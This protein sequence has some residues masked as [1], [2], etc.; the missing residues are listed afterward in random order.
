MGNYAS[1]EV[2]GTAHRRTKFDELNVNSFK[3][4]GPSPG[5]LGRCFVEV[6]LQNDRTYNSFFVNQGLG[7]C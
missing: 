2:T 5:S 4:K 6:I 3:V 7:R 1:L